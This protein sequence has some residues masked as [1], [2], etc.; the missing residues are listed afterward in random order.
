MGNESAL[1][2][3]P[4]PKIYIIQMFNLWEIYLLYMKIQIRQ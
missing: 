1:A 4:F 2:P 3:L